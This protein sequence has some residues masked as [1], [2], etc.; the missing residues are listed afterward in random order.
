MWLR[1]SFN[2]APKWPLKL[3][4]EL[5][6][7]NEARLMANCNKAWCVLRRGCICVDCGDTMSMKM[8]DGEL[9]E[10]RELGLYGAT[11]DFREPFSVITTMLKASKL[12][13]LMIDESE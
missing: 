11:E 5:L 4:D 8:L 2:C 1:W 9:L 7:R 3:I 12:E 13:F 6:D 10:L